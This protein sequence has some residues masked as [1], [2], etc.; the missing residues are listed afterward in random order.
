V[1]RQLK[2]IV[3][4]V[5]APFAP[6]LWRAGGAPRLLVLMY[7]RV[8]P[9]AHPDRARE[10]PGMYVSPETLAMHLELLKR[11]FEI[12][13]LDDWAEKVTH[14]QAVPRLACA[15]TFDDGWRDNFEFA[16]PILQAQQ[17]PATIY[18][19]PDL[20]GTQYRFWPN[21]L[22]RLLSDPRNEAVRQTW[23]E[24]L[25]E[26]VAQA[27]GGEPVS[28]PLSMEKIDA[29]IE[30]CKTLHTDS[31]MLELLRGVGAEGGTSEDRDLMNWDEV[32]QM[33]AS[34]WVRFGSH[35][36]R[37]TRLDVRA[38]AEVL[39]DEIC[40]S[41]V[42][43]ERELHRPISSFCYPNGDHCPAAVELV[44]SSYATAVTT[45]RGWNSVSSDR[46]LLKR[47]GVHEDISST[48]PA[49][50]ARLSLAVRN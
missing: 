36:R 15:V 46:W 5:M 33:A 24:W 43:L 49:F 35:T 29:V 39:R 38:A 28:L 17:V 14:G 23:P 11:H 13:H 41:Q 4:T 19:L 9:P 40:Q 16:F 37:H 26:Q 31:A 2:H 3:Q 34:G 21:E 22:A 7:H 32:R 1:K 27:A 42:S 30:R 10:Q 48:A 18:L 47:V 20:V 45:H 12:V 25:N 6:L 50:L 8:L 44:R